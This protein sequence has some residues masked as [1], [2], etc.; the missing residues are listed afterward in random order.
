MGLDGLLNGAGQP[1]PGLPAPAAG[2]GPGFP[3]AAAGPGDDCDA[4]VAPIVTGRVDHD[5]LDKLAARLA[6]AGQ[7]LWAGT[8]PARTT[9]GH[10]EECP[11]PHGAGRPAG[12]GGD[13]D[14]A[15]ARR[16]ILDH[17]VALLSGPSGLASWLRTGT[18]PPPAAAVSLPLDVGAVTDIIPAHLRRAIITRDRHCAFPG[19][20]QPR[21]RVTC[22]TSF[23]APGTA[24]PAWATA[25]SCAVS[26]T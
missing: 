21:P 24:P 7:G 18:L 2:T 10:H 17:A 3:A 5:L 16:L 4:A 26:T 19:C 15:A 22:T 25:C 12:A 20:D 8:D 11:G 6:R 13:L 14:R 9:P 1:G 23:P